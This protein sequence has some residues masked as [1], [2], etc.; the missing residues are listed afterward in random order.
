VTAVACPFCGNEHTG[1]TQVCPVT[2]RRLQGLLP[3]GTMVDEKYRIDGIIGVGGMGVVYKAEQTRIARPVALKMLLPEYIV[4]PDL[5]ARVEREARTAGQIDHPNVVSIVDL[6]ISADRGPY[7]A[8]ELLRG[9]E[10]ATVVEQA[11]GRLDPAEAVDIMVQVLAGL[12]AAHRKNVIHRDLKPENIF[13]SEREDGT[14][15]AAKVLDFGISKLRDDSELNSLTRTGT[16]MGTPQFMAPE[17]AAGSRDQDARIDLYASGAVLYA[18]LCNGL[19]YEAENYNLLINEILNK[20]PIQI[21]SRT[22]G[23]DP[24]LAAIVMKS[25]AKKADQRFQT[26]AAMREALLAWYEIRNTPRTGAFRLPGQRGSVIEPSRPLAALGPGPSAGG[27]GGAGSAVAQLLVSLEEGLSPD[28]PLYVEKGEATLVVQVPFTGEDTPAEPHEPSEEIRVATAPGVP[29]VVAGSARVSV[30][31]GVL[32]EA[33]P[34]GSVSVLPAPP[35]SASRPSPP[36]YFSPEG[37]ANGASLP[38]LLL[39][40]PLDA[41]PVVIPA[42]PKPPPAEEAW[43]RLRPEANTTSRRTAM[44]LDESLAHNRSGG[45]LRWLLLAV[46]LFLVAAASLV[47]VYAQRQDLWQRWFHPEAVIPRVRG[48]QNV[49]LTA[50]FA[51]SAPAAT[52]ATDAGVGASPNNPNLRRHHHHRREE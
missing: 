38:S 3:V 4:Y 7:I 8:M 44:L 19:P 51:P 42:S 2:N 37:E 14:R 48:S 11:G 22:A 23:L 30:A 41:P 5:V 20:P 18:I 36:G 34:G 15:G 27:A 45:G 24:R 21:L 1:G 16:V 9:K 26:A 10:L 31:A 47:F 46:G 39:E 25:I 49:T 50:P 40:N 32:T 43:A 29:S 33:L 17:Q 13:L 52:S 6:G 28:D 35:G 12:D